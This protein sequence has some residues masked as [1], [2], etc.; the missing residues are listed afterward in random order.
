VRDVCK[1][2]I[3]NFCVQQPPS[4]AEVKIGCNLSPHLYMTLGGVKGKCC[5]LSIIIMSVNLFYV[6]ITQLQILQL[7]YHYY[8]Y[9]Y[10]YHHHHHHH[11]YYYYLLTYLLHGA[12]SFLRS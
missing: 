9:Y 3:T 11:H 7:H 10:Y 5:L 1:R 6:T 12:E 4:S 2:N 8:Y